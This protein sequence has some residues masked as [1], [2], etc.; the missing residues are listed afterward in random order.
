[1]E[2]TQFK[3]NVKTAAAYLERAGINVPHTQLLEAI[4]RAFGERNWST[5]RALLENPPAPVVVEEAEQQEPEWNPS[6][7]LMP[8]SLFAEK[9]GNCCPVCGGRNLDSDSIDADGPDAWDE[10][11]CSDCDSSYQTD[12][13]VTGYSRVKRG[14]RA[15]TII[16]DDVICDIVEDVRERGK[17]HGFAVLTSSQAM[18]LSMET[19]E[20]LSLDASEEE[21]QEAVKRLHG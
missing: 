15:P 12:Y 1:M 3:D 20:L 7:G 10:T 17:K 13:T 9:G 5:M 8:E 16:R 18:E 14:S 11:V 2:T 4:S 19:S 21:L 6:V